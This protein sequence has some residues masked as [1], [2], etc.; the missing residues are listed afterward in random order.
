VYKI[1]Q[2]PLLEILARNGRQVI[3]KS[4]YLDTVTSEQIFN[5]NGRIAQINVTIE[6]GK[7]LKG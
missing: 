5:R 4:A 1:G 3:S 6:A 7:L 2:E